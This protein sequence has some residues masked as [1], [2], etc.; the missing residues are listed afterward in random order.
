MQISRSHSLNSS[1]SL[2]QTI[3]RKVHIIAYPRAIKKRLAIAFERIVLLQDF[4]FE[5]LLESLKEQEQELTGA[6]LLKGLRENLAMLPQRRPINR[7][8]K[9]RQLK[10][11]GRLR[12]RDT[13]SHPQGDV[14]A[15]AQA[16]GAA[17]HRVVEAA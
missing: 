15:A 10:E 6:F 12:P 14:R 4:T 5:Q 9:G 13:G 7:H 17:N 16:A 11:A 3:G 8:V 1:S 2:S